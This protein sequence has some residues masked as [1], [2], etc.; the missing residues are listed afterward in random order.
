MDWKNH[1]FLMVLACVVPL[2]LILLLPALGVKSDT[3]TLIAV[4]A[5]F[6]AHLLMMGG[7]D[8]GKQHEE[9]GDEHEHH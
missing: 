6:G 3:S 5:M 2:M 8:H 7:H 1:N 4:V 9:K